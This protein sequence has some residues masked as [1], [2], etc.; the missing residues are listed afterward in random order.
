MRACL[1]R[2]RATAG[3]RKNSPCTP[4]P[5]AFPRKTSP[6]T[7]E[8]T[9][10]GPFFVRRANFFA[11]TPTIRPSRANFFAHRTPPMGTLKPMTPLRPLMQASMKPPSPMLA[12]EQ[13]ALKPAT[14][15][16]PKNAPKT[17]ISHPQR[18]WRFQSRLDLRPQRRRW[19]Q[20][21]RPSGL[22]GLAAAPAGG[23]WAWPGFEP[24]RPA[25]RKYTR[26]YWC[27]GSRKDRRRDRR[28]LAGFEAPHHLEPRSHRHQ[29]G[30]NCTT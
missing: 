22:Q 21:T 24:T 5:A 16:Q 7:P 23:G 11:L 8:N 9:N 18:R 27:G 28:A 17:P 4:P 1:R 15:L 26:P 25:T 10:F 2:S 13:Q 19:F 3:P 30:G 6:G 20:T 12:P 14:P 29:T